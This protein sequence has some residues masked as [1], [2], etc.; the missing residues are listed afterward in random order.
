MVKTMKNIEKYIMWILIFISAGA[1]GS[2]VYFGISTDKD[3]SN[4]EEHKQEEVLGDESKENDEEINEQTSD[5]DDK[6]EEQNIYSE[7]SNEEVRNIFFV[8]ALL[9]IFVLKSHL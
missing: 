7:I 6:N 8:D 2:A 1:I 9:A 5:E 4:K 3:G